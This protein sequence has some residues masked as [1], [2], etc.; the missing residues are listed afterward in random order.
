MHVSEVATLYK[1]IRINDFI[2]CRDY[3]EIFYKCK[4][5]TAF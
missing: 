5:T 1:H 3:V 2:V 4:Q